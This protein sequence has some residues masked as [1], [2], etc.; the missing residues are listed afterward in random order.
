MCTVLLSPGVNP[1]AVKYIYIYTKM[2]SSMVPEGPT[3]S[4][5]FNAGHHKS[6]N[7]N[8]HTAEKQLQVT[9]VIPEGRER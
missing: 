1:N 9:G 5:H 8:G 2:R 4:L 7:D 3:T 6:D